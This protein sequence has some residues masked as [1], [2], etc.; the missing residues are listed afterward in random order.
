M[1]YYEEKKKLKLQKEAFM[2]EYGGLT[3]QLHQL[4]KN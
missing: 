1:F 4:K 2:L 3:A